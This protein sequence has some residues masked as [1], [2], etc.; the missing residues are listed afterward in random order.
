MKDSGGRYAMLNSSFCG[1]QVGF[2]TPPVQMSYHYSPIY[3]YTSPCSKNTYYS[4]CS[5]CPK[6]LSVSDAY[7]NQP[8]ALEGQQYGYNV[9]QTIGCGNCGN[10]CNASKPLYNTIE[11]L[12]IQGNI[13]GKM[14]PLLRKCDCSRCNA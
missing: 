12:S 11:Q 6:K 7:T 2:S 10:R 5:D 1:A 9:Q 13:R 8:I 4:N 14:N 3:S